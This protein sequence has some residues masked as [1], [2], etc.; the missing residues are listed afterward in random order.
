MSSELAMSTKAR[1]MFGS[2]LQANEYETL[3]QKKSVPEVASYLKNETYF[4]KTLKRQFIEN[5]WNLYCVWIFS[6][7]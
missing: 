1:A 7:A 2:R 3:I 6:I 4:S 5:C